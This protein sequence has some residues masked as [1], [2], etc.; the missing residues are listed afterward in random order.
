MIK[1]FIYIIESWEV[2]SELLF[3]WTQLN[4]KIAINSKIKDTSRPREFIYGTIFKFIASENIKW[5]L[6]CLLSF[7]VNRRPYLLVSRQT[8]YNIKSVYVCR[9]IW[10]I[11]RFIGSLRWYKSQD[12][13]IAFNLLDFNYIKEKNFTKSFLINH[14]RHTPYNILL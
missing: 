7:R 8:V 13:I 11:G 14:S 5:H 1:W 9:G 6:K 3:N 4:Q 10:K 2:I 12:L